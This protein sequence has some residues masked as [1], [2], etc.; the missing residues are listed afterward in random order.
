MN[1]TKGYLQEYRYQIPL[2]RPGVLAHTLKWAEKNCKGEFGW[3][4]DTE[5]KAVMSFEKEKD[6]ILWYLRWID[7]YTRQDI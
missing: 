6:S 5:S 7:E 3:Y 2:H 1:Y 4:F